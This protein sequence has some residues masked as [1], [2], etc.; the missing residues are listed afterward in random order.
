[1]FR[2][3][4]SGLEWSLLSLSGFDQVLRVPS[5][6]RFIIVKPKA[7]DSVYGFMVINDFTVVGRTWVVASCHAIVVTSLSSGRGGMTTTSW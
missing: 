6:T 7:G 1:M 5:F 2:T 3:A 4:G